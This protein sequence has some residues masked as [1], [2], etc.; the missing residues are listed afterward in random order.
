[1]AIV[2][3]PVSTTS[4]L[5]PAEASAESAPMPPVEEQVI[6][7][8]VEEVVPETIRVK[9]IHHSFVAGIAPDAE[10]DVSF[11]MWTTFGTR[12]FEKL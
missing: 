1:M 2:A 7:N 10:G 12:Y 8:V 3:E 5:S 11:A 4:T 6:D 9:N